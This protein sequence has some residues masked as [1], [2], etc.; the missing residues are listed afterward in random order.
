[1]LPFTSGLLF[2]YDY[3]VLFFLQAHLEDLAE[4][5]ATKK[6]DA[7]SE[8]FLAEL[9]RDSKN[10]SGGGNGSSKHT[11]VKIKDK[12]KNK[13]NQKTKGSRVRLFFLM[14]LLL[15]TIWEVIS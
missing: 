9:A 13:G 2:F 4:K 14:Q 3:D 12:K 5:D 6:S 15:C 10:S 11:H 1:M 7:A 8:A